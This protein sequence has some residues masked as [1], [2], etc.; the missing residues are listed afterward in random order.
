MVLL[1]HLM[2]KQVGQRAMEWNEDIRAA[3]MYNM[4]FRYWPEQLV[5]VDESSCDHWI[6]WGYGCAPRGHCV[7][8]KTVFVCGKRYS[9]TR[10]SVGKLFKN[11]QQTLNVPTR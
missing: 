4:S 1:Q 2:F 6:S 7:M 5:F 10:L 11:S 8:R 9:N 3:Y